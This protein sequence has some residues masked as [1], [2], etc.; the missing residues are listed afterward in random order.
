MSSIWQLCHQILSLTFSLFGG[1]VLPVIQNAAVRFT[2]PRFHTWFVTPQPTPPSPHT[3]S[4]EQLQHISGVLQEGNQP[5]VD[6]VRVLL[7]QIQAD[8]QAGSMLQTRL[9]QGLTFTTHGSLRFTPVASQGSSSSA[10]P[11]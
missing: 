10:G 6:E 5:L 1:V 9:A 3:I 8:R 4:P 2:P 7:A 11:G